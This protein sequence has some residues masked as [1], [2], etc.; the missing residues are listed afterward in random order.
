LA[1]SLFRKGR[2]TELNLEKTLAKLMMLRKYCQ[3]T[4][5]ATLGEV[6]NSDFILC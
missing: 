3:V 2:M 4:N 1:P 5:Q 6:G